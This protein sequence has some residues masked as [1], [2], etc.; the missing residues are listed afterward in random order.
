[1]PTSSTNTARILW[2]AYVNTLVV[3]GGV[4]FLVERP[5]GPGIP[6]FLHVVPALGCAVA[7]VLLPPLLLRQA[8]ARQGNAPANPVALARTALVVRMALI[9]AVALLGFVDAWLTADGMRY[10]PFALVAFAL[11]LLAFPIDPSRSE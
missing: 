2:L 8:V 11:Q 6:Y 3:L 1:M 7:S 10:L 5:P 4:A 9:E